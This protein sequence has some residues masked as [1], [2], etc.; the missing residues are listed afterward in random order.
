MPAQELAPRN[1]LQG[2]VRDPALGAAGVGDQR[3]RPRQRIQAPEGVENAADG[4]RQEDQVRL[5]SRLRQAGPAIYSA[6]RGSLRQRARRTDSQDRPRESRLAH[7]Q[8]ERRADQ[9]RPNNRQCLH[10]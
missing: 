3:I 5:G 1:G 10:A 8:P 9:P 7:R 6:H 4:L 2:E